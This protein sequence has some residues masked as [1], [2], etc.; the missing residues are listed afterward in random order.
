MN[1]SLLEQTECI[2]FLYSMEVAD[3][4]HD[5]QKNKEDLQITAVRS[6]SDMLPEYHEHY[7]YD[8]AFSDVRLDP[9][10]IL[11]SSGSTGKSFMLETAGELIKYAQA[12]LNQSK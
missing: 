4:V 3:R 5:L 12:R 8:V 11:H 10:L 1:I 2:R 7:P 6:L 9:V